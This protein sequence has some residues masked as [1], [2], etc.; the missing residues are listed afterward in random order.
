[1]VQRC[2]RTPPV[3]L[4]PAA[5]CLSFGQLLERLRKALRW[6]IVPVISSFD[7]RFN[8]NKPLFFEKLYQPFVN[9]QEQEYENYEEYGK[10]IRE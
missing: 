4:A 10:S 9:R 2:M 6:Q 7:P 3:R 5:V 8:N 1:M